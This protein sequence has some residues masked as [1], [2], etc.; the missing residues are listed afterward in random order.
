MTIWQDGAACKGADPNVFYPDEM[1]GPGR[2]PDWTS[3]RAICNRCP[4][5]EECLAHAIESGEEWGFWGGKT[6][7]EREAIRTGRPLPV[8]RPPLTPEQIDKA[9]VW[10]HRGETWVQIASWLGRSPSEVYYAA[11]KAH[12]DAIRRPMQPCGTWAA[13]NRHLAAGEEPCEP[14]K[15]ASREKDRARARRKAT[16]A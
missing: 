2:H 6:A 14:C 7:A 11:K 8:H 5:R 13:Y 1:P 9:L 12:G 4:V 3:A 16:A 10:H 15:E